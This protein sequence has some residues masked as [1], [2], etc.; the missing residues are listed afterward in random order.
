[1]KRVA[2]LLIGIDSYW[3]PGW[4]SL[5]F[6]ESDCDK[7]AEALRRFGFT[8]R[9]SFVTKGSQTDPM[10]WPNKPNFLRLLSRFDKTPFETFILY[11]A[12]HGV[13][14]GGRSYLV[15]IDA[16]LGDPASYIPLHEVLARLHAL[17]A[18]QKMMILDVCHVGNVRGHGE[19]GPLP[20]SFD[21]ELRSVQNAIVISACNIDEESHECDELKGGVFT[22]FWCQALSEARLMADGRTS[23]VDIMS[24]AR[25][26]LRNWT[27]QHHVQQEPRIWGDGVVEM[28]Q[29]ALAYLKD[30]IERTRH[31]VNALRDLLDHRALAPDFCVRIRARLSSLALTRKENWRADET[32]YRDLLLQERKYLVDAFKKGASLKVIL[33]WNLAEYLG[34][35]H[36]QPREA[37]ARMKRL[38]S[39]CKK[40]LND[41]KLLARATL[42]RIPV[43][44]RNQFFLGEQLLFEG[45]KLKVRGGFDRTELIQDADEIEREIEMFDALFTD[46]IQ[47]CFDHRRKPIP[48]DVFER[49]RSL[50]EFLLMDIKRDIKKLKQRAKRAPRKTEPASPDGE[51]S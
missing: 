33:A 43:P 17:N 37:L 29:V 30:S 12:G 8:R 47:Y 25:P 20:E 42:I 39:F 13:E 5:R 50:L 27:L 4:P 11:F 14:H 40:T 48:E 23:I 15:P 44:E 7:M 10:L 16:V 18:R 26:G 32:E 19:L 49:N 31:I 38:R 22:H 1:M 51:P 2:A 24:S 21:Q 35:A 46:G 34:L 36:A 9:N 3:M 28:F 45:R 6:A 41:E